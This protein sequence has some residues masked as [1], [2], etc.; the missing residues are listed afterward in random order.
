MCT[1]KDDL[2]RREKRQWTFLELKEAVPDLGLIGPNLHLH[3]GF[4]R[5]EDQFLFDK[6][7]RGWGLGK[8]VDRG[9]LVDLHQPDCTG[10]SPHLN[11]ALQQKSNPMLLPK[12]HPSVVLISH[13]KQYFVERSNT[14]QTSWLSYW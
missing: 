7:Q 13:N 9:W 6:G 12:K 14:C 5:S 11:P 10:S 4:H 2:V 3:G 8:G 1:L